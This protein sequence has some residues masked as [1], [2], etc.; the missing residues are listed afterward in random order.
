MHLPESLFAFF[1]TLLCSSPFLF[2]S[3]QPEIFPTA[4]FLVCYLLDIIVKKERYPER[5][6]LDKYDGWRQPEDS[7]KLET[8]CRIVWYSGLL[9][10]I[11]WWFSSKWWVNLSN[12]GLDCIFCA[13]L[14]D[15]MKRSNFAG[16]C[17]KVKLW[18]IDQITPQHHSTSSLLRQE[19]QNFS[20]KKID[21]QKNGS[22]NDAK[23]WSE[24]LLP[25]LWIG[26]KEIKPIQSVK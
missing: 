13:G 12:G 10:F 14:M 8:I 4:F 11:L 1:L 7:K 19:I 26:N 21:S 22:K 5:T 9:H 3:W 20:T 24:S 23:D 17:W 25:F 6:P 15:W 2:A 16:N 18:W